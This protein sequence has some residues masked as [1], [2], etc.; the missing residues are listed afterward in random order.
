M[1]FGYVYECPSLMGS[2]YC[3]K[4]KIKIE[5]VTTIGWMMLKL[6]IGLHLPI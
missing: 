4:L 6:P 5:V 3:Y 1:S 2:H